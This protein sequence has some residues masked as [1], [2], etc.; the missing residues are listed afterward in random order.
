MYIDVLLRNYSLTHSLTV[1]CVIWPIITGPQYDLWCVWWDVKPY[2]ASTLVLRQLKYIVQFSCW[3]YLHVF[4]VIGRSHW[5]RRTLL[6]SATNWK[7]LHLLT[8]SSNNCTLTSV[9]FL[10][11]VTQESSFVYHRSALKT[12]L[13]DNSCKDKNAGDALDIRFRFARYPAA[14]D[15]RFWFHQCHQSCPKKVSFW[16]HEKNWG[17][18]EII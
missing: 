1:G 17:E 18:S 7:A 6:S 3:L 8:T 15:I 9:S 16:Y 2:S 12:N 13:Q 4:S 5:R 14:F 10:L 11:Q